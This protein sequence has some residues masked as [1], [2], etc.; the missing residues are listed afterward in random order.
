MRKGHKTDLPKY[1]RTDLP[2]DNRNKFQTAALSLSHIISMIRVENSRIL[3]RTGCRCPSRPSWGSS[4]ITD[5]SIFKTLVVS[6]AATVALT[7][8]VGYGRVVPIVKAHLEYT[9]VTIA[10]CRCRQS[11]T[12][13]SRSL[14]PSRCSRVASAPL[15]SSY[16]LPRDFGPDLKP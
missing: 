1:N 10:V 14:T 13:L 12:S 9:A 15:P 16:F 2:K 3:S 7:N 8:I 5:F 4:G 6:V 11:L